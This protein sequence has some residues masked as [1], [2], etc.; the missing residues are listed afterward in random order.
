MFKWKDLVWIQTI[1]IQYNKWDK[2]SN[3]INW[4][5]QCTEHKLPAFNIKKQFPW[6][7]MSLLLLWQ[8][9][10]PFI[11]PLFSQVH[12]SVELSSFCEGYFLQQMPALLEREGF[13]SLLLGPPGARQGNSSTSMLVHSRGDSPLEELE[14]T[15]AQRL[16]SLYVSSRVWGRQDSCWR[17]ETEISGR[18][19]QLKL[20]LIQDFAAVK[21]FALWTLQCFIFCAKHSIVTFIEVY[22]MFM[23]KRIGQ[24]DA[25][26]SEAREA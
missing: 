7:F 16:R 9:I 18:L 24:C 1:C 10:W 11:Y 15:L 14:A 13:R 5:I 23:K 8:N 3:S 6:H 4:E 21:T 26:S 2:W 22:S 12:G 25:F 20:S 19:W 17:E